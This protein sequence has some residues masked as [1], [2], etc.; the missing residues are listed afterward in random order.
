MVRWRIGGQE[1]RIGGEW[2]LG[3]LWGFR[4]MIGVYWFYN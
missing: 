2:V 1:V 3:L 4:I